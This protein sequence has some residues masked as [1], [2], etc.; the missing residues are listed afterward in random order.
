MR[1]FIEKLKLNFIPIKDLFFKI[2]SSIFALFGILFMFF[3]P[4]ELGIIEISCKVCIIIG[5]LLLSAILSSLII[6]CILKRKKLWG[7]GNNKV[8]A[9]YGDLLKIAF[10][11]KTKKN[12]IIVIPVND[13]FETI[14][15]ENSEYISKPL[16]S[17]NTL[18][19]KWIKMM[20]ES[21]ISL[22]ELNTR[23]QA[24]LKL[25]GNVPVKIYSKEE[26]DRGNL[27]SYKTGT[28]AIIELN[29]KVTFYLLVI[30]T[31][32]INN[33]AQS[34]KRIIWSSIEDL[35]EFY[36]KKGQGNSIFIPL[37]GTGSS[38]TGLSHQQSFRI[39]KST[40][41]TSDKKING[42]LN[43]VVYKGDRDKISIF[44]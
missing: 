40:I 35:I 4:D 7:N 37:M 9:F 24:N 11:K 42:T 38:R 36:D 13:T 8:F 19:G 32:D 12:K 20:D 41:D 39:L 31:F 28:V 30:S 1:N 34:E 10:K 18:H 3:T 43:I 2:V 33:N 5:T 22:D 16:V 17:S 26:K 14:I 29:D 21:G 25:N 15:D 23:I 44:K 6:I 27:N